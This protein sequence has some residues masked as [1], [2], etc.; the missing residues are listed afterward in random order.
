MAF[1]KLNVA[2]PQAEVHAVM[3]PRC[4]AQCNPN[5]FQ[6]THMVADCSGTDLSPTGGPPVCGQ[7][8]F[9]GVLFEKVQY[10]FPAPT[11]N[12]WGTVTHFGIYDAATA[13]NLLYW[14]ALTTSRATAAG[15][16]PS[17]AIGA[18]THTED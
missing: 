4:W 13:G 2:R 14:A 12:A 1:F 8:S 9:E 6:T 5:F 7:Q 17:F 3:D 16:A 18:L 10:T 15:V 11:P